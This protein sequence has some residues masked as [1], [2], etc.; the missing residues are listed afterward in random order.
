MSHSEKANGPLCF[1]FSGV[2]YFTECFKQN[3]SARNTSESLSL[4]WS[5]DAALSKS[6]TYVVV[7]KGV[8]L[9]GEQIRA[10]TQAVE[11]LLLAKRHVSGPSDVEQ[12]KNQACSL[13][14][15]CVM[16][17]WRHQSDSQSIK[18]LLHKKF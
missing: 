9:K 18:K 13:S 10:M 1:V 4:P 11:L 16:L 2:Q 8:E 6:V 15:F 12:W 14:H 5:R 3:D 7:E 17:V